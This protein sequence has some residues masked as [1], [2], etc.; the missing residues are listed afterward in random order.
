MDVDNGCSRYLYFNVL[1][2]LFPIFT[3]LCNIFITHSSPTSVL[4]VTEIS[5]LTAS[6]FCQWPNSPFDSSTT[7][8]VTTPY[9]HHVALLRAQLLFPSALNRLLSACGVK[10]TQRESGTG[11]ILYCLL[12]GVAHCPKHFGNWRDGWARHF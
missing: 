11:D 2:Y 3:Y 9:K 10:I 4:S 6:D 1:F 12:K 8:P 7:S 5:T